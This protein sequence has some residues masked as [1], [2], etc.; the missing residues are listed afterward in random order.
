MD[1]NT[2]NKQD[3]KYKSLN[4]FKNNKK[5]FYILLLFFFI[6]T[7]SLI[8]LKSRIEKQNILISEKFVQAGIFLASNE[9]EKAKNMY[10]EIIL[11]GSK[12]YS[13]L[14]LNTIL[15]KNLVLD[16]KKIL[17]Y[18]RIIE[19]TVSN[20]ES[21]ELINLKKALYL[22]KETDKKNGDNLL[23]SLIEKNSNLKSIA[24]EILED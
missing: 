20:K 1:E 21:K 13:I 4:F 3:L 23:Q 11:S 17:N 12:F 24:K 6:L 14:S 16:K 7:I 9:K 15:E 5:K 19:K 2:D 18:F 10:E 8:Y 22:I